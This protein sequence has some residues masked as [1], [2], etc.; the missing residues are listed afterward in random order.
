MGNQPEGPQWINKPS[1]VKRTPEK[2]F[3][4]QC[5]DLE[6]KSPQIYPKSLDPFLR[7]FSN[8]AFLRSGATD[9]IQI[10]TNTHF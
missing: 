7:V 10:H 2:E 9:S 4:Y 1:T 3:R 5:R 8:L 6:A